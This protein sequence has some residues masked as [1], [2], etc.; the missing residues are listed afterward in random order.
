[1][2]YVLYA[3]PFLIIS[4]LQGTPIKSTSAVEPTNIPGTPIMSEIWSTVPYIPDEAYRTA[5]V[6]LPGLAGSPTDEGPRAL[7]N[8]SAPTPAAAPSSKLIDDDWSKAPSPFLRNLFHFLVFDRADEKCVRCKR[9]YYWILM[10]DMARTL[11]LVCK[12]WRAVFVRSLVIPVQ[13]MRLFVC[14][15]PQFCLAVLQETV[16]QTQKQFRKFYLLKDPPP[17]RIAPRGERELLQRAV[18]RASLP[19]LASLW[20]WFARRHGPPG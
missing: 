11:R 7:A 16:R 1:M 8:P 9:P 20:E 10:S 2:S 17:V 3:A 5:T 6:A 12:Q 15:H 19:E 18:Q 14:P 13:H 4:H